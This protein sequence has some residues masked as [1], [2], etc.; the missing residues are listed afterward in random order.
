M[1][2]VEEKKEAG[3]DDDEGEEGCSYC[4]LVRLLLLLT[5]N[6]DDRGREVGDRRC[7]GGGD[8]SGRGDRAAACTS[9]RRLRVSS[10]RA[11]NKCGG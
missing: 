11:P 6:F 3:E 5:D 9:S 4:I 7:R 1:R 2:A 10:W 8:G